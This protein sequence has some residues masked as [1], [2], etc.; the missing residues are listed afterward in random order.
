MNKI[1]ESNLKKIDENFKKKQEEYLSDL[2]FIKESINE[3][4]EFGR[5]A[6]H[7][8]ITERNSCFIINSNYHK[9]DANNFA[10]LLRDI[11][12]ALIDDGELT[13][14]LVDDTPR[15]SL[16]NNFDIE[17]CLLDI[18]SKL[19]ED[20]KD[21]PECQYVC[22]ILNISIDEWIK[23]SEE[24]YIKNL[25]EMFLFDMQLN[26][27]LLENYKKYEFFDENWIKEIPQCN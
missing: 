26:P 14:Y 20:F 23:L 2:D 7:L 4:S 13:F 1:I 3:D 15:F 12:H 27:E 18:E 21:D 24:Y 10:S 5:F 9:D 25:K 16:D 22:K 11:H 6:L 17:Y 8:L 19:A